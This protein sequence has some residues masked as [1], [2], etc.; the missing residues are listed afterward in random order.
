MLHHFAYGVFPH[1]G[2][3]ARVCPRECACEPP[4]LRVLGAAQSTL[5][6]GGRLRVRGRVRDR[7]RFSMRDW[8]RLRPRVRV[9]QGFA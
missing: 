5:P 2:V 6:G 3:G 4:P 7:D 8:V 9:R 1:S